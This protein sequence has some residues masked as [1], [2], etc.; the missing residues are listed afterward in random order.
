MFAEE[1]I[2]EITKAA[3]SLD[4]EP[5][6]LLAVADVESGGTAF[7]D[8]DGRREP[9]IRF[10]AHYFDRRLS[11]RKRAVAREKGLAAPVAGAIANPRT[12]TA[13]WRMLEQAAAIDAKAAYESV[14]WG[15]GQV[16]G[17]HW[18]WLGYAD[19][20]A[21]VATARSG[22]AGQVRLMM[23]YIDKAGLR[24]ALRKHDWAGFARSYNGP[25]YKRNAYETKL[26]TA[27]SRYS[28]RDPKARPAMPLLKR[29]SKGTSVADLQHDLTALG[30]PLAAD[31][32]FG[33]AT[34]QAVKAFQRD[35]A[36][37]IDGIVGART[38][39]AIEGALTAPG[40]V[41]KVWRR[42]TGWL[43]G[44]FGRS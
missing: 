33:P 12:Q 17:A 15:L 44:L 8:V 26:A 22:V 13:R 42:L 16:M 29:G 3:Q 19:V 24:D 23:Q 43:A 37:A 7:A 10:E 34:V 38:N 35:H 18:A 28:S 31:G 1:I 20:D 4:I 39:A 32:V 27:Y 9:L 25:A 2:L 36:L 14:S 21:L 30:Y 41:G 5:A 40:P 6:A 11:D